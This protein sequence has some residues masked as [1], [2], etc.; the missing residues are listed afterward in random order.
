MEKFMPFMIAALFMFMLCPLPIES[1]A[2]ETGIP[3]GA[4]DKKGQHKSGKA[5]APGQA[6]QQMAM[7][8]LPFTEPST[9][10]SNA[11]PPNVAPLAA[12]SAKET[13][14]RV[15]TQR[16]VSERN[17]DFGAF[18]SQL[19]VGHDYDRYIAARRLGEE[20]DTRAALDLSDAIVRDSHPFVRATATRGY[21]KVKKMKRSKGIGFVSADFER[22]E[23]EEKTPE[24][25]ILSLISEPMIDT[26]SHKKNPD[27]RVRAGY[28]WILGM[29]KDS[30]ALG[31]LHFNVNDPDDFVRFSIIEAIWRINDPL[32]L[33]VLRA[34]LRVQ[35]DSEKN[36]DI[37]AYIRAVIGSMKE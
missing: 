32:S 10:A 9:R 33:G 5:Q 25:I 3:L 26:V 14:R 15:A 7:S 4:H 24:H 36:L 11:T 13:A 22:V 16:N 6:P 29:T 19:R 8:A 20:G 34:R 21:M 30:R 27:P 18:I 1:S 35:A 12:T 37:R 23:T 17:D 28:V 31:A 2:H